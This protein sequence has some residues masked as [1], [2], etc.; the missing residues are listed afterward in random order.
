MTIYV[1][2]V[3]GATVGTHTDANEWTGSSA[4]QAGQVNRGG[5][6]EWW[7][8]KL[9]DIRT[10]DRALSAAAVST[11]FSEGSATSYAFDEGAGATTTDWSGNG[12]TGTLTN[13]PTW[14]GS[15]H[16][17]NAVTFDGSNDYIV[18]ASSAVATNTSFSVSA[19]ANLQAKGSTRSIVSQN[20]AD[21]ASFVLKYQGGSDTWQFA[22]WSADDSTGAAI[23]VDSTSSISTGS[24]VFLVG[25][26][27]DANNLMKIY[28]NGVLE[29]SAARADAAE[30]NTTNALQVGRSRFSTFGNYF[31]GSI[32]DIDTYGYTLTDL[33]IAHLYAGN[34]PRAAPMTGGQT[35]ALQGAQQG[36]TASDAMAFS[37]AG[38]GY[39]PTSY[40]NPN[41]FTIEC[42]IKESGSSGG[43]IVGLNQSQTSPF[44]TY[45]SDR[46]LYIDSGQ[47]L[48]FGVKSAGTTKKNV[49]Y[50]AT[51]ATW[52]NWHHVAASLGA[53]G[54][55]LYVDGVLVGTDATVTTGENYTGYWRWGGGSLSGW[56]NNPGT[57]YFI[58]MIDEVAVYPSQLTDQN[59]AR[60]YHA[61][62]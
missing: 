7:A 26:Y 49:T 18:A 13:G 60:H 40:A 61:N 42:W 21:A 45:K 14:T 38:N 10:Y 29:D 28:V 3:A 4:L 32:D 9:D 57:G 11:L 2:G 52:A 44:S 54:M 56:P 30:W 16:S 8:G 46:F 5:N 1:N 39:N 27:D 25:V 35:G 33:Q 50:A 31:I 12:N 34:A 55:K 6:S 23:G 59:I 48:T 24:W 58:G 19:W 47:D 62:H 51:S 37:G 22:M 20:G 15:G 17:G 36:Q 53:A 41:T 43:E